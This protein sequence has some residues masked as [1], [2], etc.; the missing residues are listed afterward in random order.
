MLI[1]DQ[2]AKRF[3]WGVNVVWE[4]EIGGE[5]EQEFQIPGG[6]SYT[7]IDGRL[8]I[9]VEFLYDH[10]TVRH[11]RGDPLHQFNIGPSLQL[12]VTDKLHVD[13]SCMF[14]TNRD[15]DREIG[16]LIVGYDFGPGGH[17]E[18]AYVPA[19]GRQN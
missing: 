13:L 16:F 9:G 14:G 17:S 8:S 11:Q 18:R 19:A 5:R 4:A 2:F 1:G 10:D 12:R 3:H 15:S 7:L 6:L